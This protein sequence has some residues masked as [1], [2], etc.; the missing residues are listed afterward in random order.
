ML[1]GNERSA[2]RM[3]VDVHEGRAESL[4]CLVQAIC[5]PTRRTIAV[6]IN[7]YDA[8]K[9][10]KECM[11][12]TARAVCVESNYTFAGQYERTIK[13]FCTNTDLGKCQIFQC[14]AR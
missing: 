3:L 7:R 4:R 13:M 12:A 6:R 1:C 14:S 2:R 9:K 5:N 11:T 8:K 10:Q